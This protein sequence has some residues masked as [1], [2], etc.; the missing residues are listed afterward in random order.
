VRPVPRWA[1]PGRRSA[2]HCPAVHCAGAPAL[3]GLR[4]AA[5]QRAARPS[6]QAAL[7]AVRQARRSAR[8][9]LPERHSAPR[10]RHL[11]HCGARALPGL[12]EAVSRRAAR[13]FVQG[14][15]AAA[16]RAQRSAPPEAAARQA[17]ALLRAEPA[18]SDAGGLPPGAA[19]AAEALPAAQRAGAVPGARHAAEEPQA[20]RGAE[21]VRAAQREAEAPQEVRHAG[22]GVAARP[23]GAAEAQHVA[24]PPAPGAPVPLPSGVASA[25]RRDPL[26]RLAPSRQAR[27]AR[28]TARLRSASR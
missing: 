18:A 22:A 6:V 13:L 5:N 1:Q 4:A 12:R 25:F 7:A 19:D 11:V 9:A 14:A 15:L 23:A 16:R 21:A 26:R 28:A 24:A 2:P 3:R 20:L 27:F 8:S 10:A 17:A